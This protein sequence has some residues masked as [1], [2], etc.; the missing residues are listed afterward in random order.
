ML[1]YKYINIRQLF[2]M[3][4]FVCLTK[5]AELERMPAKFTWEIIAGNRSSTT[6]TTATTKEWF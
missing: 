2:T 5:P 3:F 1:K 6:A 4:V